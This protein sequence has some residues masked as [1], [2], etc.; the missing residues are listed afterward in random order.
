MDNV[1]LNDVKV[2]ESL[3]DSILRFEDLEDG[4]RDY[5]ETEP[6]KDVVKGITLTWSG[7]D[8]SIRLKSSWKRQRPAQRSPKL[9]L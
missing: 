1:I 5:K 2:G 4:E 6:V 3:T 8:K 7:V 9:P